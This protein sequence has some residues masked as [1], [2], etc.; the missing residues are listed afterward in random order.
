[1]PELPEVETVKRSLS[2]KLIGKEIR[3]LEIYFS[4][5]IRRPDPLLMGEM[6]RG[7]KFLGIDRRGKYLIFTLSEDLALV[8][9]L[10]MTGQLLYVDAAFPKDKHTHLVFSLSDGM[11]L[12]YAD[13][14][15]FG[16][17]DLIPLSELPQLKG[18]AQLGVEPLSGD[19]TVQWLDQMLQNKNRSIKNVL[20]DQTII[21]GIGNIYADEILYE[22][23]IHPETIACNLTEDQ[24][25]QLWQATVKLLNLGIEHRGTSIRNYVD[26]DGRQG[27]FQELLKVYG[28]RGEP[29]V[30]CGSPIG[31]T[32]VQGRGT[33]YCPNCQPKV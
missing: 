5:N 33:Y 8:V 18:L 14:R 30:R 32:M 15:K 28:R 3:D 1:M 2:G 23:G 22:G 17:F 4:G 6:I 24:V 27:G 16:T 20:L 29:C 9:H 10:R 12:R 11:E 19:F 26:G 21:A 13:L 31:K 25:R 7:K